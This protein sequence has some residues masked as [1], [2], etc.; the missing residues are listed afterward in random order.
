[1]HSIDLESDISDHLSDFEDFIPNSDS[2]PDDLSIN[3]NDQDAHQLPS[4][5][6]SKSGS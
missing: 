2:Y 5:R 1:M 3:D 4:D 6:I